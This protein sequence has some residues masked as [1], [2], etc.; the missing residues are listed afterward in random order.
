[1]AVLDT[2]QGHSAEQIAGYIRSAAA[3]GWSQMNTADPGSWRPQSLSCSELLLLSE[4]D[5]VDTSCWS[6]ERL[7]RDKQQISINAPTEHAASPIWG[8]RLLYYKP[9]SSTYCGIAA[10][11]TRGYFDNQDCPPWETWAGWVR[12]RP[13]LWPT[14]RRDW[15]DK[16]PYLIAWVHPALIAKVDEAINAMSFEG[17]IG[18]LSDIDLALNQQLC[19]LCEGL[20][21]N[22]VSA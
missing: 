18:W 1:M 17:G 12:V 14:F 6:R 5:R 21:E 7:L 15:R 9:D 2:K 4:K 22:P 20:K 19:R 11:D 3:W 10:L 8:G 13:S 16:L